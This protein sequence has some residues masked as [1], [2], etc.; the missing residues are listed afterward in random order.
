[1]AAWKTANV[2]EVP[3]L[4]STRIITCAN[5]KPTVSLDAISLVASSCGYY[6][7][8]IEH[9][10]AH[11]FAVHVATQRGLA[12]RT[13]HRHPPR[14]QPIAPMRECHCR[15]PWLTPRRCTDG[16]PTPRSG[17]TRWPTQEEKRPNRCSIPRDARPTLLS[18]FRLLAMAS[19]HWMLVGSY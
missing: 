3:S 12:E 19:R 6:R 7:G 8:Q 4:H 18:S 10:V 15:R 2:P 5:H 14:A 9:R 13:Q 17:T 16:G 11:E 1:M